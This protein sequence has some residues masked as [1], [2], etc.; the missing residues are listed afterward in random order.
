MFSKR[1]VKVTL[2]RQ[3]EITLTLKLLPHVSLGASLKFLASRLAQEGMSAKVFL[4]FQTGDEI[5]QVYPVT[6]C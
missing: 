6:F 2:Y 1:R 4:P 5:C 3:G